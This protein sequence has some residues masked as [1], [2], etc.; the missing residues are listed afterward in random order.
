VVRIAAL[1]ALVAHAVAGCD[2]LPALGV[3]GNGVVEANLGEDCDGGEGCLGCVLVCEG[4]AE[5]P[6][7]T[8]PAGFQCGHDSI[9]RK[10]SGYFAIPRKQVDVPGESIDV[11]DVDWDGYGDLI[12]FGD[13][14]IGVVYGSPELD[15]GRLDR[16][17]GPA[18]ARVDSQVALIVETDEPDPAIEAP[19]RGA[20]IPVRIGV[21]GMIDEAGQILAIPVPGLFQ[22]VDAIDIDSLEVIEGFIV[23]AGRPAGMAN[24][25]LQLV[26]DGAVAVR[27][28]DADV[29]QLAVPPRVAHHR[30]YADSLAVAPTATEICVYDR[31]AV[32]G[33]APVQSVGFTGSVLDMTFAQRGGDACKDLVLAKSGGGLGVVVAQLDAA[34]RCTYPGD[35]PLSGAPPG[36]RVLAVGRQ[37]GDAIDDLLLGAGILRAG[38]DLLSLDIAYTTGAIVD[39]N[40]DG[41]GDVVLGSSAHPDL[42]VLIQLVPDVFSHAIV[43][44]AQPTGSLLTGD[45]DGDTFPDVIAIGATPPETSSDVAAMFGGP[46]GLT[47]PVLV[48][49]VG[50]PTFATVGYPAIG[51]NLPALLTVNLEG[52][53]G[54]A[55]RTFSLFL[56]ATNRGIASVNILAG[57]A[58]RTAVLGPAEPAGPNQ[59]WQMSFDDDDADCGGM[60]C[61]FGAWLVPGLSAHQT[62]TPVDRFLDGWD[63]EAGPTPWFVSGTIDGA[64][65]AIGVRRDGYVGAPEEW[66]PE[67]IVIAPP[68]GPAPML[69]GREIDLPMDDVLF[70]T[71]VGFRAIEVDGD[72]DTEL[73]LVSEQT[74]GDAVLRVPYLVLDPGAGSAPVDLTAGL[75]VDCPDG[76]VLPAPDGTAPL[77]VLACEL[78]AGQGAGLFVADYAGVVPGLAQIGTLD[79]PGRIAAG[80]VNG[81]GL[82]D[83]VVHN[84]RVDGRAAGVAVQCAHHATSPC[85]GAQLPPFSLA[86]REDL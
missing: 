44:T 23:L 37:D 84:N 69:A 71:I 48:A 1:A 75:A 36:S 77:I 5:H 86:P 13:A 17:P 60:P 57:S 50:E 20:A 8:C 32:S 22:T 46:Q 3:C 34:N 24:I 38:D 66:P 82:A 42:D 63:A 64:V 43:R 12:G 52:T 40:D 53:M 83:L 76:V 30:P 6:D 21:A 73:L 68:T 47:D 79:Q 11:A 45:F 35:A 72:A 2:D 16:I 56:G 4:A 70:R 19:F 31:P 54:S 41:L 80:D 18:P 85:T 81:D 74:R 67:L 59:V 9:C 33:A 51:D 62:I 15:L 26:A 28:C 61:V 65:S 27:P 10:P 58:T 25:V 39:V 14:G 7:A 78:P 29:A 49:K 55:D